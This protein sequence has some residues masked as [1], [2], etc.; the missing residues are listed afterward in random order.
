MN[1]WTEKRRTLVQLSFDAYDDMLNRERHPTT[2][3]IVE[4]GET[5]Q[6]TFFGICVKTLL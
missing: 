3:V 4:V 5:L 1:D 6:P 2:E